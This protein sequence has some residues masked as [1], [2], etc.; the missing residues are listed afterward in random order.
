MNQGHAVAV[1]RIEFGVDWPPGHVACY[2]VDAAEPVLVDAGTP[3]GLA[4]GEETATFRAGLA[5]AGYEPE[6]IEHL[7]VTHPH[8]DHVGQVPTVLEAGDP[9]VYAPA[10]VR[11][12]FARDADALADRVRANASAYGLTGETLDRE[13]A[14]AVESLERDRDL[15]PPDRVDVWLEPGRVELGPLDAT[16][17]HTPGHQADHLAYL[18]DDDVLLSGDTAMAPFRPVLLHD[19]MDDGHTEAFPGAFA[20]LDRL[21][22]HDPERVYPGHG[23]VHDRLDE[24]VE[25]DRGKLTSRLDRVE[26]LVADGNDTLHAVAAAL[27]PSVETRRM[28][29]ETMSALAHLEREGRIERETV[30]GVYRFR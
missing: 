18:L 20:A 10:G 16:A 14:A 23:E 15:L 9:T 8:V 21:A 25:R 1:H 4:G 13:V 12:R 5:E 7:V 19:G 28:F 27:T 24:V 26:S 22:E 11:E 6:D 2:L 17:V 3:Q 29:S 30:E